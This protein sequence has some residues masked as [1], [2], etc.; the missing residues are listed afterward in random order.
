MRQKSRRES[1]EHRMAHAPSA[2]DEDP[3]TSVVRG[4]DE[5]RDERRRGGA[6]IAFA[7]RPPGLRAARIGRTTTSAGRRSSGRPRPSGR[8]IGTSG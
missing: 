3:A 4:V 1:G 6:T 7:T 5:E 2:D 8:R